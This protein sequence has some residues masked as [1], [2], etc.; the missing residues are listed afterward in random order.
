MRVTSYGHLTAEQPSLMEQA[1]L[2]SAT[3]VIVESRHARVPSMPSRL[4]RSR[5][6]SRQN[7]ASS[8][9]TGRNG[10]PMGPPISVAVA[11]ADRN[12]VPPSEVE[13]AYSSAVNQQMVG[14]HR[15][16]DGSNRGSPT[17]P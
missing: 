3:S 17:P 8:V 15:T 13:R 10:I 1:R 11:A 16:G 12:A 5:G 14:R 2:R 9:G 7:S 4:P 6:H